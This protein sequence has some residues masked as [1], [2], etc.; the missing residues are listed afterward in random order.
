M[1]IDHERP[2]TFRARDY[3][4]ITKAKYKSSYVEMC[5]ILPWESDTHP[6]NDS[7]LI[8]NEIIAFKWFCLHVTLKWQ[9]SEKKLIS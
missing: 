4:L 2:E 3:V 5:Y 7:H 9:R 8:Y 1:K 6:N